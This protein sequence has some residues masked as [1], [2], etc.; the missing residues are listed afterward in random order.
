MH[1]R[2]ALARAVK[3]HHE[4]GGI[5]TDTGLHFLR[6]WEK[7]AKLRGHKSYAFQFRRI[8]IAEIARRN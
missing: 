1:T 5:N 3:Q 8:Y 6:V 4:V 2:D 7:E